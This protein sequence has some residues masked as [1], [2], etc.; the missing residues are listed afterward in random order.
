MKSR[1]LILVATALCAVVTLASR[2]S[3]ESADNRA[4]AHRLVATFVEAQN[5]MNVNLFDSIIA[6]DYIQHNPQVA[7]GLSGVK[8]AFKTEFEKLK[9]RRIPIRV[10]AEDVVIDGDRVVL[11]QLTTFKKKGKWYQDRSLDEWR[12]ANGKFVE[13]WD[14]DDAPQPVPSLSPLR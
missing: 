11:R 8:K 3:A 13:H 7:P 6:S 9:A 14:N 2:A 1:A 5:T 12:V 10:I 4:V